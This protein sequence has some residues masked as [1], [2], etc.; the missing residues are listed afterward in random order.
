MRKKSRYIVEFVLIGVLVSALIH[1]PFFFKVGKQLT[2]LALDEWSGILGVAFTVTITGCLL[3]AQSNSDEKREKNAKVYEQK[4]NICLEFLKEIGKIVEDSSITAEEANR[5]K[6]SFSYVAIHL[7]ED[8]MI[9]ISEHLSTIAQNCGQQD[10]PLNM[11]GALLK[12]V[13]IIRSEIYEGEPYTLAGSDKI[14]KNLNKVDEQVKRKIE[15]G[16]IK[17]ESEEDQKYKNFLEGLMQEF[18]ESKLNGLSLEIPIQLENGWEAVASMYKDKRHDQFFQCRLK[19]KIDPSET[20][21]KFDPSGF[22][23]RLRE[24]IGGRVDDSKG[25]WHK[26][27]PEHNNEEDYALQIKE[28]I[29]N[30]LKGVKSLYEIQRDI[31][32]NTN[33]PADW[34]WGELL[35]NMASISHE[36]HP[37]SCSYEI[38]EEGLANLVLKRQS[39]DYIKWKD[40][41]ITT[42]ERML[43]NKLS[44]E[45]LQTELD[46]LD[47]R[48]IVKPSKIKEWLNDLP[49]LLPWP[50][51]IAQGKPRSGAAQGEG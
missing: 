44:K 10:K 22:Y 30:E 3:M 8:S 41:P 49:N 6:F 1:V 26:I 40:T 5:L 23:T 46:K 16:K 42:D 11:E 7:S 29:E 47:R 27:D 36:K 50:K 21:T 33:L 2:E 35:Y 25:W 4:L 13:Q 14:L 37:V 9:K 24:T 20:K 43:K 31:E 17:T 18:K 32:N 28:T 48:F 38:E 19:M 45:E 34:K 51:K 15:L 12:I 39:S